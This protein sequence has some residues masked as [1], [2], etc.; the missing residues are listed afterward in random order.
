MYVRL[1]EMAVEGR[2]FLSVLYNLGLVS[3]LAFSLGQMMSRVTDL[4]RHEQ[5]R[6]DIMGKDKKSGQQK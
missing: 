1:N 3:V 6:A 2:A 4:L 5:S